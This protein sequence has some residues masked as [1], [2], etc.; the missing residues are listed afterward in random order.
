MKAGGLRTDA[1]SI[2]GKMP[3]AKTIVEMTSD[4]MIGVTIS[5][6]TIFA[7]RK[8]HIMNP[9]ATTNPVTQT[10]GTLIVANTAI[11][12]NG[13]RNAVDNGGIMTVN[14]RGVMISIVEVRNARTT[15]G[16]RRCPAFTVL[17]WTT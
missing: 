6:V 10:H 17:Q 1:K 4:E 12:A 15:K 16:M 3:D 2:E 11:A 14:K 5:V 8:V 13:I 9:L 7:V